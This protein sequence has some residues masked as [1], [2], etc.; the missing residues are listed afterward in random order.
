MDTF[1]HLLQATLEMYCT[2]QG[3]HEGETKQSESH[4]QHATVGESF[5]IQRS[6]PTSQSK[7]VSLFNFYP[8]Q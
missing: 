4:R 5:N 1:F 7:L 3:S 8:E 2:S 6:A